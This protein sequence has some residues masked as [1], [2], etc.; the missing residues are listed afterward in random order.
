MASPYT[1]RVRTRDDEKKTKDTDYKWRGATY[2]SKKE[3]QRAISSLQ[4]TG[5]CAQPV[6]KKPRAAVATTHGQRRPTRTS[7]AGVIT[8]QQLHSAADDLSD[9]QKPQV[10]TCGCEDEVEMEVDPEDR[11]TLIMTCMTKDT[12]AWRKYQRQVNLGHKPNRKISAPF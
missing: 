4:T 11:D 12:I 6:A 8:R 9:N 2:R 5:G 7:A 10:A 3:L 1:V